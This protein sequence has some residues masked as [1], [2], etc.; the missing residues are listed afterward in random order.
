MNTATR[1]VLTIVGLLLATLGILGVAA[2][3][4]LAEIGQGSAQAVSQTLKSMGPSNLLVMPATASA[5]G[6]LTADDAAA[7]AKECGDAVV[8]VAPVVRA[9]T[10][11]T[12]GNKNW[13]PL[14]LYGTTPSFLEVREWTD[15][16]EG[17]PFTDADVRNGTRVCLIGQTIKRELFNDQSPLGREIRLQNVTF[18]VVGVLSPRGA[19]LMGMD[20]DDIVLAPWTTIKAR[21]SGSTLTNVNQ[22]P[23]AGADGTTTAATVNAATTVNSLNQVYPGA[24]DN[25][26]PT[27]SARTNIDQILVRIDTESQIPGA[28]REIT[29]LLQQR[30]HIRPNQPDDF[31][32]RDLTELSGAVRTSTETRTRSLLLAAV[33]PLLLLGAGVLLLMLVSVTRQAAGARRWGVLRHFLTEAILLSLA[34]G[35]VGVLL[36]RV[37]SYLVWEFWGWPVAPAI[38]AALSALGASLAIG[39]VFGFFPA[40][41]ASRLAPAERPHDG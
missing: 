3:I 40:W 18:Q 7:I 25:I 1:T 24:Q 36:G 38:P 32:I 12:V 33:L 2:V 8:G 30:H 39:L 35:I 9:R 31:N 27:A 17:E 5:G 16:E 15:L 28:I 22:S 29:A 4:A 13:V 37:G 14:Y 41:K 23:S 34:G 10:Q 21:V 6:V 20:Q 26:Y 11:V 19:N